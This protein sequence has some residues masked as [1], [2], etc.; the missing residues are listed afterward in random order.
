MATAR[1]ASDV[2]DG[3]VLVKFSP[4]CRH[5]SHSDLLLGTVCTLVEQLLVMDE[6]ESLDTIMAV[7]HENVDLDLGLGD[8]I[9]IVFHSIS[10]RLQPR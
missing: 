5:N 4:E 9:E 3:Q 1:I 6:G 10:E 2:A 7:I 8:A